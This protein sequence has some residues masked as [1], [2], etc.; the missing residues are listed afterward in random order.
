M[1]HAVG[2]RVTGPRASGEDEALL[3]AAYRNSLDFARTH[4]D[5]RSIVRVYA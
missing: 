5:I 3:L 1:I 2:P 4:P